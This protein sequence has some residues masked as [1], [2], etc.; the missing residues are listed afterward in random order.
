MVDGSSIRG[1]SGEVFERESK[2]R[3]LRILLRWLVP[4]SLVRLNFVMP[5]KLTSFEAHAF[6]NDDHSFPGCR[7]CQTREL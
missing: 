5:A 6:G 3:C 1:E 2:G 4:S 7:L